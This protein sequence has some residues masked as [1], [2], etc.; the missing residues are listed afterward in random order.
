MVCTQSKKKRRSQYLIENLDLSEK[1]KAGQSDSLCMSSSEY[2]ACCSEE[3]KPSTVLLYSILPVDIPVC[4]ANFI[5]AAQTK[6]ISALICGSCV[7]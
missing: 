2:V 4:R 3:T 7:F 6:A 5:V 1:S